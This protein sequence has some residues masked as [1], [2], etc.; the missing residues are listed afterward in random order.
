MRIIQIMHHSLSPFYDSIDPRYY[1]GDWHTRLAKEVL[2]RT[3]EYSIECWRP[4]RTVKDTFVREENGITYRI[5]PSIYARFGREYSIPLLRELKRQSR[6]GKILIHLHGIHNH[7]TFLISYFFKNLP[8]LAQHHGS[9][10]SLV[11]LKKSKHPLRLLVLLEYFPEKIAL[12]NID[13]FFVLTEDERSY[14][15]NCVGPHK[16]EVQT[17][18]IDFD[19][20]KPINK[21]LARAELKLEREK[22][23][24]LYVGHLVRAKGL[25]YLLQALP[26]ILDKYPDTVLLL[27][28]QGIYKHHLSTMSHNLGVS[29]HTVFLGHV[30]ND[31]LPL[32]YSAADVFVLPS[33]SEGA[34]VSCIEAMACGTPVVATAV[35]GI[36]LITRTFNSG[37]LIPPKDH[38]AIGEAVRFVLGSSDSF[39]IDRKKGQERYGWEAV[40]NNTLNSYRDLFHAYYGKN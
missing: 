2:K 34:P 25:E 17:M 40:V 19:V 1:E 7:L 18:G 35:G 8:I 20:F 32:F 27:A 36:P 31:Q 23:Y 3:N 11:T 13:H 5:F 4:E 22:K 39:V 26:A 37:N 24:L 16:V 21:E 15:A 30:K 33:L 28:G 38:E 9:S 6:E 10:P 29:E 14:L 12:R